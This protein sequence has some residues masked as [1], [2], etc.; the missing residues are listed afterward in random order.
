LFI[1]AQQPGFDLFGYRAGAQKYIGV[2]G[3]RFEDYSEAFD[4]VTRRERSDN[5]DI[6]GITG[7]GIKM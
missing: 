5:L 3:G 1:D 4:V 7:A 6:A 2:P